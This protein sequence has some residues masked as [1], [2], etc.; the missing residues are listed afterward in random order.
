LLEIKKLSKEYLPEQYPHRLD[1]FK[2]NKGK[3]LSTTDKIVKELTGFYNFSLNEETLTNWEIL[4]D[5]REIRKCIVHYNGILSLKPL[6]SKLLERNTFLGLRLV[7]DELIVNM[8]YL[9]S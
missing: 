2:V 3:Q 1:T 5:F 6:D 7:N 4:S 8:S 9:T